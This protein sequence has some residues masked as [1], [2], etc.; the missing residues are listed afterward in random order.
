M[1]PERQNIM[2]TRIE[3]QQEKIEDIMAELAQA[4]EHAQMKLTRVQN[5]VKATAFPKAVDKDMVN[6]LA[7]TQ[8]DLNVM[9]A[10][11][12]ENAIMLS[13]VGQD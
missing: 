8:E 7:S 10:T 1:V 2:K 9:L 12:E 13:M 11:V 5:C 4:I 3:Q 6:V